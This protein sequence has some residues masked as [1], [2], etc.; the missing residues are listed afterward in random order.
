[1]Y[2]SYLD[3]IKKSYIKNGIKGFYK[4]NVLYTIGMVPYQVLGRNIFK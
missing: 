2:N 3:C 1:M 4:G